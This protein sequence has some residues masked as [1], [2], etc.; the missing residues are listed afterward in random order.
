MLDDYRV[1]PGV[2]DCLHGLF[3]VV[4]MLQVGYG[5]LADENS[6]H[7]FAAA[8]MVRIPMLGASRESATAAR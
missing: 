4:G 7:P 3:I 6:E 2:R 1:G 8:E 5:I